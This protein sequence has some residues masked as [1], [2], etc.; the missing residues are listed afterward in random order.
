M[1][2]GYSVNRLGWLERLG[3]VNVGGDGWMREGGFE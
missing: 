1:N 3:T 2:V